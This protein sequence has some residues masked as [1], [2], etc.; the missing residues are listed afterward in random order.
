MLTRRE[1][2]IRCGASPVLASTDEEARRG[3]G[4]RAANRMRPGPRQGQ[5]DRDQALA[6]G[7][8]AEEL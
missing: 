5:G 3:A 7:V 2:C 8:S 1:C 4:L 6:A